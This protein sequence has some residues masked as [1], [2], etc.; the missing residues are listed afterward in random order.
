[1]THAFVDPYG[2]T[3]IS[4]RR[5]KSRTRAAAYR[6]MERKNIPAWAFVVVPAW[7]PSPLGWEIYWYEPNGG[8]LVS[9]AKGRR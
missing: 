3:V 8:T 9:R 2:R 7:D 1:M 6:A 4:N 5:A